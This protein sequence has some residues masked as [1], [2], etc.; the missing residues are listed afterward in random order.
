MRVCVCKLVYVCERV[1]RGGER[2]EA[3][4]HLSDE[5]VV[6]MYHYLRVLGTN[7]VLPFV[8]RRLPMPG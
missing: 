6:K 4:A 5:G 7:D 2:R 3:P 8:D 1:E